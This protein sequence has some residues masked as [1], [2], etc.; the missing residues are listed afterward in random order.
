MGQQIREMHRRMPKRRKTTLDAM[1]N[2]TVDQ[3]SF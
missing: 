3:S 1:G 2:I